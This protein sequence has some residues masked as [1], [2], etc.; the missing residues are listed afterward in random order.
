MTDAKKVLKELKPPITEEQRQAFFAKLSESSHPR[1]LAI[2]LLALLVTKQAGSLEKVLSLFQA[3]LTSV[4]VGGPE[5]P[6]ELVTM[7]SDTS[8]ALWV[9]KQFP[10]IANQAEA[11]QYL[12]T[13]KHL[14]ILYQILRWWNNTPQFVV[15]I[16]RYADEFENLTVADTGGRKRRLAKR[17]GGFISVI[18]TLV[19][20]VPTKPVAI[21]AL[22]DNLRLCRAWAAV[23]GELQEQLQDAKTYN[24]K[25]KAEL[26]AKRSECETQKMALHSVEEREKSA[27]D[28]LAQSQMAVTSFKETL[29]IQVGAH[30]AERKGLVANAIKELRRKLLPGLE[31]IR[32][33]ADREEP[34][35]VAIVR[36]AQELTIYITDFG[37]E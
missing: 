22:L 19:K 17:K 37:K 16:S 29:Q 11:G 3:E 24:A 35:T 36:N 31:N 21:L 34:N 15:A 5:A 8:V 23:S 13:E 28:L 12:E 7:D 9:S 2:R 20:R 14:W 10:K 18:N 30:E 1:Q 32:L 26:D 6:A 25:L 27:L 33:Y 4:L